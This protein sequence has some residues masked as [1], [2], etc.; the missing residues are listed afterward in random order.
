MFESKFC[1]NMKYLFPSLFVILITISHSNAQ[2]ELMFL[3]GKKI[4]V[5]E[6]QISRDFNGDSII[7]YHYKNRFKE[8]YIDE[9]FSVIDKN[10]TEFILYKKD[11]SKGFE[12]EV[13]EMKSFV[14]GSYEARENYKNPLPF[15][16][17]F[18]FGAVSSAFAPFNNSILIADFNVTLIP[19]LPILQTTGT[20]VVSNFTP[21]DNK[22]DIKYPEYIEDQYFKDGYRSAAKSKR[23]RNSLIGGITGVLAGLAFLAL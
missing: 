11:D 10:N 7:S 12:L 2:H 22:I 1:I 17:G 19:V 4:I 23:V 13:N 14:W 8:K 20:S 15:I 5:G 18:A 6:Y 16:G 9:V 3:N 21:S